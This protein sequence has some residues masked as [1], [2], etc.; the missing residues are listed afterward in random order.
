MVC[1][2]QSSLWWQWGVYVKKKEAGVRQTISKFIS[3]AHGG[4]DKSLF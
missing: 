2:S 4:K 3:V 1:V